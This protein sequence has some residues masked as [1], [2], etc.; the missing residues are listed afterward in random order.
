MSDASQSDRS[1]FRDSLASVD[2]KGRRIWIYPTKPVGGYHQ[3]RVL[4]ATLLIGFLFIAPFLRLGG[5][6]LLQFDIIHR[7]FFIFG[8]AFWPQ[9]FHLFV[10]ITIAIAI[11]VILFTAAFGR[12]FCGWMCPQTIF[13]EMVFR[14][15]EQLIEGSGSRQR[16]YDMQP[17]TAGKL[18]KKLLKHGIFFSISF[19]I[20]NTFLAYII[21]ADEVIRIATEPPDQHAVG[22]LFMIVF[23]L[24]FY[25]VFARLREQVCTLICPYGRL[26]SVLLDNNSI[27]VHYDFKRGEP[28][29]P[30]VTEEKRKNEGDCIDCLSC[31]K[32][33]PTGIDIR[34]GTQLEC[35]NCTACI[36]AC[37]RVMER[38]KRPTGLIRYSSYNGI[39]TGSS[40]RFTGR[41]AL[42]TAVLGL[43][44]TIVTV[45]MVVRTDVEATILRASGST[46]EVLDT[47]QV[48][49]IYTV[50]I[51]N[52]TSH[53]MDID[54]KLKSKPGIL[55]LLGPELEAPPNGLTES[56]FAILID[57]KELYAANKIIEIQILDHN[58]VIEEV[59]TTFVGP[60]PENK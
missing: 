26:Q 17:M 46:F 1:S 19:L 59:R 2:Q 28:K 15:I 56:V 36:D 24:I 16:K 14:K 35:I 9:D 37:N 60:L 11:F 49:N 25:G 13:M 21:G 47:G 52:K 38:V 41:L 27:V 50:K 43:L 4:V 30:F 42:Y 23:S 40:F 20:G 29:G 58:K 44:L 12:I 54:L 39:A 5:N 3:A 7:K 48:R 57:S 6:Q 31:V 18:A 34:N 45:L 8:L 32:V 22:L 55:K 51:I 53:E 33:C 10:L